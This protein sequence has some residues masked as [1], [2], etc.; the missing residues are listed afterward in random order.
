[1][2]PSSA[3]ENVDFVF[4]SDGSYDVTLTLTNSDGLSHSVSTMI[5]VLPNSNTYSVAGEITVA[6]TLSVDSDVN[7]SIS[8]PTSNDAIGSAQEISNPTSVGGYINRP[9]TGPDFDGLGHS[10]TT[11]DYSD[12]YKIQ[13]RGRETVNL[14]ISTRD[15]GELDLYLYDENQDIVDYSISG[16]GHESVQIPDTPGTYYIE[17]YVYS[18]Y[19]NYVLTIGAG[20]A[21]VSS[22]GMNASSDLVIGDVIAK[23]S[24]VGQ[25]AGMLQMAPTTSMRG[26]NGL[27]QP[28]LYRF[29]A[30]MMSAM[31]SSALSLAASSQGSPSEIELKLQ[32]MLTAKMIAS[33]KGVEFAEPNY[34]MKTQIEPNDSNY[35]YQWHYPKIRLPEAW[36]QTTGSGSVK[37][38]VLDTGIVQT[39]PDLS[40]RLSSDGYD[41]VGFLSNGDGDGRDANPSDQG[42]GLDNNQCTNSSRRTSSFHGT[43][44]AGTI[45]AA[46][47]NSSGVAGVTWS[48]E[49]MDLRVL[50][51]GGGSSWDI[52]EALKYAAGLPNESGII[53]S[54]PADIANMSLGGGGYSQ[55]FQDAVNDVRAAGM[56]V[57]A[58]AGNDGDSSL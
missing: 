42:D 39:H 45:G 34:M 15:V 46:T 26:G 5:D 10:A 3:D 22:H 52:A 11:G 56:I 20:L 44:V 12:Y 30:D 8:T 49:I 21:S 27:S 35:R 13:A 28:V 50:G 58:A 17:A 19:S 54:D 41:F 7:D 36:D 47:N 1:N 53:V 23:G 6:P 31:A 16:T 40:G 33:D 32:T 51:C 43:H 38:A 9:G 48:T 55:F 14:R 25:A 37:V 24:P 29:G 57:I 2:G 4:L 18:G